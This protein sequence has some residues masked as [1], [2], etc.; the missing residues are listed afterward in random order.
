[1][2]LSCEISTMVSAAGNGR[3]A[4]EKQHCC[5][6]APFAGIPYFSILFCDKIKEKA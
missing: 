1:M 5:R 6:A 3:M 4:E 2:N